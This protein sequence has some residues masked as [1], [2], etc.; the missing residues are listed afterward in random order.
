MNIQRKEIKIE[1][2]GKE[3]SAILDFGAAIEFESLTG[4][5]ILVEIQEFSKTQS[6]YTLA[7]IMAS[8][9]KTKANKSIGMSEIKKVDLIS[10]LEYFVSKISE[11]FENSLPHG[12][13]DSY[14]EDDYID[15]EEKK[16]IE[17]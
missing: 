3:Y 10:G 14:E 6:M 7:A 12:E 5:S 15:E 11:L 9:I 1:L 4:K 16:T 2:N 8:V 13:E 17:D